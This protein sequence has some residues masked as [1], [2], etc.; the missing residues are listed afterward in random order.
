M[1]FMNA[2]S[3]QRQ[4]LDAKIR[5]LA[6]LLQVQAPPAGW[7]RAIRKALGISMQQLGNKLGT[8][9]QAIMEME[10]REQA[11]AIT[12][13]SLRE[14]AKTMDLQL[15]YALIPREGSLDA[16]IER[17]AYDLAKQIVLRAAQTMHLE[18]QGNAPERINQAI[19]ER[20]SAIQQEM[21]KWIWD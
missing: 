6:P 11:G 5:Q 17:R 1:Y 13:N 21:P 3:L 14:V 8:S 19:E 12:L 18:D 15:V 20:A 9:K 2:K 10:K 7:I 4:H 16:L